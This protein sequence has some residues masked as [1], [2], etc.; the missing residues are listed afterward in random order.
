[1][2][3]INLKIARGKISLRMKER[4]DNFIEDYRKGYVTKDGAYSFCLAYCFALSDCGTLKFIES[5]ELLSYYRKKIEE[6]EKKKND[7]Q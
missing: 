6:M 3:N 5:M 2:K 1:M 4:L 7:N